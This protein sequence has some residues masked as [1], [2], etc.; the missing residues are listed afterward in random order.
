MNINSNNILHDGIFNFVFAGNIGDVQSVDTII[1]AAYELKEI[2]NI[3]FHIIGDGSRLDYCKKLSNE[4]CLSNVIFHGRKPLEDMPKYYSMADAMLITLKANEVLSLTLP[5]KIQS[6]MAS[7][8]PII[9]SINGETKIIVEKAECGFICEAEDYKSLSKLIQKF[10]R[11]DKKEAMGNNAREFYLQN[12][13]KETF[14]EK[15]GK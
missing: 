13:S 10:C 5:G 4:L 6:Y 14:M 7:G 8:K 12:Y 11:S 15:I 3:N 9:G 2:N 1:R